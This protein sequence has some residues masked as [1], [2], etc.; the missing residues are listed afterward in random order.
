MAKSK[1]SRSGRSAQQ[2]EAEA[3]SSDDLERARARVD[4]L[5]RQIRRHDDLYYA[6]DAP[7][8]SD[9]EYDA[10]VRELAAVE[11]AHPELL[12]PDSPTQRVGGRPVEG[13]VS[14]EHRQP[15]LSL[16]NTYSRE[17]VLEWLE[18]ITAY[19]GGDDPL[20]FSIEPKLD[21]VAL[22]IVYEQ[23]EL[24][25]AVTRGDGKV[26]DDVTHNVVTIRSVP[27]RLKTKKPPALLE[28]R[29]EVI[30][31][32]ASFR[33][34]NAERDSAGEEPFVNPRNL[35]SGTLKML[36]PQQV[37][38][39]PLDFVAYGFG[40]TEG[41][42][43]T[44]H[45]EAIATIASWGLPTS[46]ELATL[47]DIESVLAHYDALQAK[48][49]GL[50]FDVDGTVI[51]VDDFALQRRLGVR[52][53]SPR[54]AIAFKFPAQQVTSV[55]ERIEIQVGRTGALTPK[56]VIRPV[57]VGGVTVENV[58]LHNKDEIERLGVKVGARVLVERAGDVIPK[59]VA[60]TE[61]GDGEP[62]AMPERCPVCGTPVVDDEEE[63][64]VRCPNP[65]C[66][67]VFKR[68]LEHFV[69]RGALDIEGMGSKLIESLC[70][71]GLVRRLSDVFAL[72]K[73]ALAA[74]PRMGEL[75]AQNVLDGVEAAK[76]RSFARFLYALGIRHV[77]E[78]VAAL[79]ADRWTS[80]DAL[81]AVT[82]D[83]LQDVAAI[84]P[85]VAESLLGWL[86]DER[87]Q[88]DVDRMLALGLAPTAPVVARAGEGVLAGRSF[89]FT[90]A[91]AELSRR[92]AN[93][94]VKAHGGKLLSGVSSNLDV[95]VVGDKP[96]SK[97]KKANE[98]GVQVM[99]E[100]EF[101]E[102]VRGG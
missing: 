27:R 54:W 9:A 74:L 18:S 73:E 53:K 10:L 100:A 3:P 50:P 68:R 90:G 99:T 51:K 59:I 62:F 11:T 45:G 8:I 12:S 13:L 34:V 88:A 22:E 102:L 55:V 71:T 72:E 86:A 31:T 15:M 64:V 67:A 16:A 76:T 95:L 37:R 94:L 47:G 46:G 85:A 70:E 52:S 17:E 38:K 6:K 21:G 81:R 24:V 79:V 2:P 97:L 28:V 19:L 25:R 23:G 33:A 96:G 75:S 66:P 77:G 82:A 63:V 83:A 58:T 14:V 60:V 26:G 20:R 69:S 30:M 84:G 5:T 40:A 35:A 57:Y 48:R 36:D 91:L 101:L 39:R 42:A 1:A 56:A 92:E 49:N 41:F 29:G 44:S 43:A 65:L 93:E 78:T 4:E 87:E 80:L 61:A 7:E 98:L 89:L 32:H